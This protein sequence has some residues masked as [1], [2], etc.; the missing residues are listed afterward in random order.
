MKKKLGAKK[1][2]PKFKSTGFKPCSKPKKDT[3]KQSKPS[4]LKPFLARFKWSIGIK[5]QLVI[6][7]LI[8]IL[9]VILTGI[10]SY[11]K[12][13]QG[14]IT[15]FQDSTC[16]SISM[17]TRYLDYGFQLIR[18]DL[19]QLT[20]D[21][22]LIN[23]ENGLYSLRASSM[24]ESDFI[25]D[26]RTDLLSKVSSNEL[27][28]SITIVPKDYAK[29]IST[30]NV[31]GAGVF[32]QWSETTEGKAMLRNGGKINIVGSHASLDELTKLKKGDYAL[33]FLSIPNS[34]SACLVID[35]NRKAVLNVLHELN[36]GTG[37]IA[38]FITPDGRET[39]QYGDTN[40]SS[41][42][43]QVFSKQEFYK[44]SIS[45]DSMSGFRYVTYKNN[46]Y[47]F[48]YQKSKNSNSVICALVPK[49]SVIKEANQI[50]ALTLLLVFIACTIVLII[51]SII[52]INISQN[53][54]KISKKLDL[55]ANGDLTVQLNL[56]G[57]NE[58]SILA[59]NISSMITNTRSLIEEVEQTTRKVSDIS[60]DVGNVSG[61]ISTNS[62]NISNATAEIEIGTS[63]QAEDLQQCLILMDG[64]SNK[65]SVIN[66]EVTQMEQ[67]TD[68]TKKMIY[69]GMSTVENLSNH[70]ETTT[71]ITQNVTDSV[72]ELERKTIL[73]ESFIEVINNIS[74]QTNLLSLNA[75]I[76]AARAG[77]AGKGFSVVA[78]EIGKLADG[79]KEAADK[80]HKIVT[81]IKTQTKNT[82][83][84]SQD[85]QDIV[86]KQSESVKETLDVF[87]QMNEYVERL[88]RSLTQ[89]GGNT[90]EA[91][92][93]RIHTLQAVENISS[94][95]E[96]TAA[97]ASLVKEYTEEQ[98]NT[99]DALQG[100]STDLNTNMRSLESIFKKFKIR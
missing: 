21:K 67:Y 50:K 97:S 35:I 37:S 45:S 40:G 84:L 27:M 65:I 4:F 59:N 5:K 47:L 23:Y 8:P 18:S 15:N 26:V 86:K 51:G 71:A 88:L 75:C 33:S 10:V 73:I 16:S 43:E 1:F 53:M 61:T 91:N 48:I 2:L 54:N 24:E 34:K 39:L 7:F 44:K 52:S 55:A 29:F 11:W 36:L 96:E 94:V 69:N 46:E 89:V 14:L 6:G 92:T 68:Y 58:F 98:L 42:A 12:A 66:E 62:L 19:A 31:K 28:N 70:S 90:K 64:L 72:T 74:E 83:I 49:S 22:E 93:E 85:A 99:A 25:S 81:E 57:N 32:D 82:V 63:Q 56:K 80:I 79:S 41:N 38:A 9:F 17:A 30:K 95:S 76:E 13:N 77:E 60:T 87:Q 3:L 20:V 100:I 78:F